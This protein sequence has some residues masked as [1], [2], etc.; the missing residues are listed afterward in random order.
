MKPLSSRSI[1]E[2]QAF[3]GKQIRQLRILKDV[4]M[5]ALAEKAGITES[6]LRALEE[7][8]GSRV[9]TMLR[10]L[11]ALDSLD[12]LNLLAP[13]PADSPVPLTD[14]L[15]KR[16]RVRRRSY[17]AEWITERTRPA[18]MAAPPGAPAETKET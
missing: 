16:R 10:V 2:L 12:G 11:K 15:K 18:D 14:G 1:P 8:G 9:G 17:R 13:L 7:G 3:L 5:L 6:S 4:D